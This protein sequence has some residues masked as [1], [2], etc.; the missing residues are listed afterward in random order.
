MRCIVCTYISICRTSV[1]NLAHT[2]ENDEI[3]GTTTGTTKMTQQGRDI[4]TSTVPYV[5]YYYQDIEQAESR[6]ADIGFPIF[7]LHWSPDGTI[8]I[9]G[10]G[11]TKGT[12]VRSALVACRLVDSKAV[13]R[14]DHLQCLI[15]PEQLAD[16]QFDLTEHLQIQAVGEIDTDDNVVTSILS[17][18][19]QMIV[20][21][22]YIY[23]YSICYLISFLQ[24]AAPYLI[25][26]T[27]NR[28]RRTSSRNTLPGAYIC[29]SAGKDT[30]IFQ[31]RGYGSI[32][33]SKLPGFPSSEYE[34]IRS[35]IEGYVYV[36]II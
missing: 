22:L 6:S 10:G 23:T 36:Y 9:G 8:F 4:H 20:C 21:K 11:G 34:S 1:L 29:A 5:F 25:Q 15:D 7:C 28:P 2:M 35:N 31:T 3:H 13:Q 33:A 26:F 24:S 12:G 19:P 32:S 14:R 16:V 27:P 30:V 17:S 18:G